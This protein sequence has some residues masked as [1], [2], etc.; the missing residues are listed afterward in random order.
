MT[1]T[2]ANGEMRFRSTPNMS[3]FQFSLVQLYYICVHLS[4]NIDLY[5][6]Y[7]GE[8]TEEKVMNLHSRFVTTGWLL[9]ASYSLLLM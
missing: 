7:Y 4:K 8:T 9:D 5:E 1:T 2:Y 6:C 3:S